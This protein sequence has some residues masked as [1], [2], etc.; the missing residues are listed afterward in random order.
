M[1]L[2][3]HADGGL[4]LVRLLIDILG[5]KGIRQ[6]VAPVENGLRQGAEERVG[7][8]AHDHADDLVALL[9]APGV[10]IADKLR[11]PDDVFHAGAGVAV[12]VRPVVQHAADR[13]HG[14]AG[15][16]CDVPDGINFHFRSLLSHEAFSINIENDNGNVFD[17]RISRSFPSVN[18]FLRG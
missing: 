5:D 4:E 7:A 16:L 10:G 12:D 1:V 18:P 13:G 8:A 11:F 9:E 6:A 15:K 17:H 2:Q 14:N 3:G